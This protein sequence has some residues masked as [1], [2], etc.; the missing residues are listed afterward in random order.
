MSTGE[1]GPNE[2]GRLAALGYHSYKDIIKDTQVQSGLSWLCDTLLMA[3][4]IIGAVLC[5]YQY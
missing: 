2:K 4:R 3:R 1:V 5:Q